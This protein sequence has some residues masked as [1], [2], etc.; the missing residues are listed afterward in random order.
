[1]HEDLPSMAPL[2]PKNNHC[3]ISLLLPPI[4][5]P[6][7][8]VSRL[9]LLVCT[10]YHVFFAL[11]NWIATTNGNISKV[12]N[13]SILHLTTKSKWVTTYFSINFS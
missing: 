3:E 11:H 13:S 9:V 1:M 7:P 6:W 4:E 5:G 2:H 10:P 12:E 8:F